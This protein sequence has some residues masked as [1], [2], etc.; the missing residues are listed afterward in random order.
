[1]KGN[2]AK[3]FF[4]I[5]I[6]AGILLGVVIGSIHPETGIRIGIL[7]R[8][9]L[10]A[11]KMIALP[12]IVISITLSVLSL[13]HTKNLGSLTVKTLTYY[14]ITT[15]IAVLIG[16]ILVTV[17]EPGK[18]GKTQI[19]DIPQAIFEKREI[20][21]SDV[22]LSF[23]PSNIVEAALGFQILPLIFVSI[24]FG[25][26]L[27]TLGK[28]SAIIT[29]ILEVLNKALMKIVEWIILF[30]PVGILGLISERIGLEG[31][32]DA[33]LKLAL[34]LG[35]YVGT[36]LLG[37]AIHGFIVLPVILLLVARYNPVLYASKLGKALI[38]A[39]VTA[40]SS[41]TLPLTMKGAIEEAHVSPEVGRFVLPL[42]A[43]INMDG[44][45]LYEAVAVIFI[46][47]SYGIQF[48]IVELI[49]VFFTST[50]AAIGAAGIPEAG[51]VTMVLVL[52]AVGLPTEG[53]GLILTVDWLLDRFRTVVNVW[54]DCVGA[55]IIDR[56]HKGTT[57]LQITG[58][59]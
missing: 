34:S 57:C 25:T 37:L 36:V 45:A 40:S 12:L 41:A 51:L 52:E 16:I 7:G 19:K 20:G 29:Q 24:L 10:N 33:V 5:G 59:E 2:T 18:G 44:T 6:V 38:T 11:L 3:S 48:G 46:A 54:G 56:K 22:I 26:A 1:M 4:P 21:I 55:A 53:I 42:G 17:I 23:I 32:G 14:L 27:A 13:G 47:Q 58:E 50:L 28:E 49:I 8:L 30:T 15:S 31:G 35:K 43:T 9:F 39:F